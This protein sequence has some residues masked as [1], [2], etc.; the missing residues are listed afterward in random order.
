MRLA[1]VLCGVRR[2]FG[3]APSSRRARPAARCQTLFLTRIMFSGVMSRTRLRT[4]V[5]SLMNVSADYFAFK[6]ILKSPFKFAGLERKA[7][8][9]SES[10]LCWK[11]L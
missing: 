11:L 8:A 9:A 6:K 3:C 10:E 5:T 1:A 2:G 7:Q 4:R